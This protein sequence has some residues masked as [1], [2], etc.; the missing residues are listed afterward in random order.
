MEQV[1]RFYDLHSGHGVVVPGQGDL[2]HFKGPALGES[3]AHVTDP[4]GGDAVCAQQTQS[5][6]QG[7]AYIPQ[8][9]QVYPLFPRGEQRGEQRMPFRVL[10]VYRGDPAGRN[11]G[12]K[13]AVCRHLRPAF[14]QR[15][16][17]FPVRQK[18]GVGDS[19]GIPPL[20]RRTTEEINCRLTLRQ[21]GE[22]AKRKIAQ[23]GTEHM[24]IVGIVIHRH[25]QGDSQITMR[26][27]LFIRWSISISFPR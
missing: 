2:L 15:L 9:Q 5:C 4:D 24:S 22:G 20:E 16:H 27:A 8:G 6:Q 1:S 7:A 19:E 13:S 12:Q 3:R 21:G 10:Q 17:A 11:G 18:A 25:L 26:T 23:M 14:R